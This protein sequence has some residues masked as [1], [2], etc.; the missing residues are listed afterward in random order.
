MEVALFDPEP[1][2]ES[3][4]AGEAESAGE[5]NGPGRREEEEVDG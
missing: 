1:V 4:A 2:K 3:E 5:G